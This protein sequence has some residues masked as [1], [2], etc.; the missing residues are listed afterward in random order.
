M[1]K[2][3]D[4]VR[5]LAE[6]AAKE[7]GCEIWDV[8]FVKEAGGRYLRVYIDSD[9]GVTIDKC[10]ALSRALDPLL[11]EMDL[12]DGAYTFEVSSAGAERAL[13]RDSDFKKFIGS[14]VEIR[15]YRAK[16]GQ[17]EFTGILTSADD[18]EIEIDVDGRQVSFQR[19]EVANARLRI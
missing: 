7:I 3:I 11:D 13:K 6:P 9:E 19:G 1:S 16:D 4:T 12:I 5:S 17:K 14:K 2:I 18:G 10:E 8:E 15:L